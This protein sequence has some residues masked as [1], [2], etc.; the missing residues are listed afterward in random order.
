M[1]PR[2]NGVQEVLRLTTSPVEE[3]SIA[4]AD[5]MRAL[6]FYDESN[7]EARAPGHDIAYLLQLLDG[8]EALGT[9]ADY[10]RRFSSQLELLKTFHPEDVQDLHGDRRLGSHRRWLEE[11]IDEFNRQYQKKLDAQFAELA[12]LSE[13]MSKVHQGCNS[14]DPDEQRRWTEALKYLT[15]LKYPEL[16]PLLPLLELLRRP[17]SLPKAGRPKRKVDADEDL[18]RKMKK[19]VLLKGLTPNAAASHLADGL[20]AFQSAV[21]DRLRTKWARKMKLRMLEIRSATT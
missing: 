18:L 5:A 11:L 14:E 20:P 16:R 2:H 19:L 1:R 3:L 10:R 4:D 7:L 13:A 15:S 21:R 9:L 17:T 12:P 8:A 6:L